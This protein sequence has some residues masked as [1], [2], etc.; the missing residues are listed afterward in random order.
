MGGSLPVREKVVRRVAHSEF[1]YYDDDDDD[2]D[3][4]VP[5]L[6]MDL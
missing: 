5:E 2:D 4:F 6:R 3:I 1:L